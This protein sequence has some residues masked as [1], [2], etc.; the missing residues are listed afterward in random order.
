MQAPVR[1]PQEPASGAEAPGP[2]T[3]LLR[4]PG[5]SGRLLL[6]T[7][8][9]VM[10]AEVL[11]Y[12]PSIANF[13]RNWLNDRIAAARIAALVLDAAPAGAVPRPLQERLLA[14]VGA[15]MVAVRSGGA[16]R[17]LAASEVPRGVA[18][19]VDLR[20]AGGVEL[21]LDAFGS[22]L[23]GGD[24]S[25]RVVG[26]GME[27]VEFVEIVLDEAPLR[28]AMLAFS[29]T[30]LLLSLIISG[31]TAGL[32]YVSLLRMIVTPVRRL[33]D[34]IVA[35]EQDPEDDR[36]VIR[37]S[38]RRDEIGLAEAA[39]AK[40]EGALSGELRQ[41]KHL[42]DL[43]LA[44]SKINHD[45]RNML[46]SAQLFSDRL[47]ALSDPAVQRL[48]PK[49]IAAL[50]RAIGFCQATLAYGRAAE[51]PP[52]RRI[53]RLAPL[54]EE[55]RDILG[56]WDD[57]P[58]TLVVDI[59]DDLEIDAD[60][61]HLSRV[62]TNLGRN[63][64][65]ALEQAGADGAPGAARILGVAARREPGG[66]TITVSDN[67][68]GIP[69]QVRER[70][71]QAF[72]GSTRPG[73]TGLGLAIAAELVRAHGGSIVLLPDGPGARFRITLPDSTAPP[74]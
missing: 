3:R 8:G 6:L 66:V 40:M 39:L 15:D 63:A 71:F 46:A 67:G 30:I 18:H 59:P 74:A 47:S 52:A 28:A 61:E 64:V 48:A 7:V 21:V 27:G 35:F 42:A 60:P 26:E 65:Q 51:R 17:L 23:W 29:A 10:L 70:L 34:H 5:L 53:I 44:V 55:L 43:G 33:T 50:D 16:R 37:P 73:G 62:L 45:L 9:F 14:Q 19:E 22:L 20:T 24:R 1:P 36:R 13:R 56:L 57:G 2:G 4:R 32:V 68:P 69:P 58:V 38:G 41:K 31:V 12:V 72:Q 11:I 25:I 49:L 54:A